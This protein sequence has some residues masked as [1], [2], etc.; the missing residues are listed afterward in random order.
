MLLK[1]SIE[2][3][4]LIFNASIYFK[5]AVMANFFISICVGDSQHGG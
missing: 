4:K 3:V 2:Y 5:Q 1:L